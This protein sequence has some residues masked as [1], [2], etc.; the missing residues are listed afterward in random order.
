[1]KK[2]IYKHSGGLSTINHAMVDHQ[3]NKLTDGVSVELPKQISVTEFWH[4]VAL[5]LHGICGRMYNGS[6]LRQCVLGT[7]FNRLVSTD[8]Q[9]AILLAHE[10]RKKN[11]QKIIPHLMRNIRIYQD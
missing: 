8:L 5:K 7:R 4:M 11:G 3:Q 9:A 1:M 10:E 6:Y 2:R